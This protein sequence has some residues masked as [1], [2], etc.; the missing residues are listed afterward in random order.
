MFNE[1]IKRLAPVIY[2]IDEKIIS[3]KSFEEESRNLFTAQVVTSLYIYIYKLI[4]YIMS[5]MQD[6]GPRLN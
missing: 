6:V 2:S 1:Y 5:Q 3:L 4:T